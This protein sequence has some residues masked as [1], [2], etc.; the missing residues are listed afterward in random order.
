V[1]LPGRAA[2]QSFK[3]DLS[4]LMTLPLHLRKGFC[5]ARQEKA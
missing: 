3:I 5:A 2:Q 1:A 4:A